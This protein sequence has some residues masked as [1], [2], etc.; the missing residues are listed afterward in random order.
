MTRDNVNGRITLAK[1]EQRLEDYIGHNDR[2]ITDIKLNQEKTN[3]MLHE[4]RGILI[5]GNG[6]IRRNSEIV[7]DHLECHDKNEEK[8]F[9]KIKLFIGGA[10]VFIAATTLMINVLW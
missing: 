8:L 1:V 5:E 7:K 3:N 10:S 9:R 6:K 2:N 4:I